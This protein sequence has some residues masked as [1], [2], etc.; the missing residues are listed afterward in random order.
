MFAKQKNS[1][2]KTVAAL[3][4]GAATV[5]PIVW[6]LLQSFA[7]DWRFPALVPPTFTARAWSYLFDPA[8]GAG[9]ALASSL[10]VALTVTLIS[11]LLAL[12]AARTFALFDFAGKKFAFLLLLLPIFTP[13]A[14]TAIGG[15]ALLLRLFLT[16]TWAG[17]ILSHLVFAL[18]YCLLTLASG[19]AGFEPDFEAQASNLGASRGQIWRYVI[20]PALA[21]SI[22]VAAAFAFLISWSQYLTTLLVGGG[23][24]ITL[25]LLLI[26]FQRGSD[27]AVGAALTVVFL[28]PIT[29]F[30]LVSAVVRRLS[31]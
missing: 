8:S 16:D 25:P 18:P 6:L 26:S 15:H 1:P 17:L 7:R 29:I 2:K 11:L 30:L 24:I 20:L 28:I 31:D 22:T 4:L 23:K 27:E 19:F 10:V 14:A 21:P 9:G 13:S 12:P 5:V 3:V